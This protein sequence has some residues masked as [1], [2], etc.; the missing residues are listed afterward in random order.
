MPT[1]NNMETE[2]LTDVIK[3]L[4][5]YIS[6]LKDENRELRREVERLQDKTVHVTYEI[7]TERGYF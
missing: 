5:E 6:D 4:R 1:G 7:T 3:A 2:T